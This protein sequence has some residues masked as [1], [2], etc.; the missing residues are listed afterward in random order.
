[1]SALGILPVDADA[2]AF[3]DD[4]DI[5]D[6]ERGYVC[7]AVK[8]GTVF[9]IDTENGRCFMSSEPITVSQAATILSRMMSLSQPASTDALPVLAT[10]NAE[11][12][13]QGLAAMK[14]LGFFAAESTPSDTL[15]RA[16]AA[17]MLC[18]MIK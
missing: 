6:Y 2:T 13:E 5:S 15:T 1:M 10:Q 11:I 9:G 16:A 7:A 8:N 18:K 3:Y 12:T 4:T 14:S 17:V